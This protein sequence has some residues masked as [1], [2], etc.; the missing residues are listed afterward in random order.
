MKKVNKDIEIDLKHIDT[1]LS[2]L[3]NFRLIGALEEE[4]LLKFLRREIS[5]ITK[6][7]DISMKSD[8]NNTKKFLE[9]Y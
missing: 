9:V 3:K 7:L 2:K 6:F 5:E 1:P 4:N 8:K